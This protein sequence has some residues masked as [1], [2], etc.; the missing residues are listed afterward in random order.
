M[1]AG[2]VVVDDRDPRIDYTTAWYS[3]PGQ[4]TDYNRT[5]SVSG[6][7]NAGFQFTF[8]GTSVAVYGSIPP[9]NTAV[10]TYTIDVSAPVTYTNVPSSA[11]TSRQLCFQS[12]T[13]PDGAHTLVVDIPGSTIGH[14]W[15][16]F[17]FDFLSYVPAAGGTPD[18]S[19]SAASSSSANAAN[20]TGAAGAQPTGA[21]SPSKPALRTILPAVLIPCIVCAALAVLALCTVRRRARRALDAERRATPYVA[22]TP[23]TRTR[24]FSA[25]ASSP[26]SAPS[27]ASLLP[28]AVAVPALLEGGG[29]GSMAGP[30]PGAALRPAVSNPAGVPGGGT[31][32]AG[33]RERVREWARARGSVFAPS[34]ATQEPPPVYMP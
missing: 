25:A 11:Y 7:P 23:E 15:T 3:E 26:T 10:S 14:T 34:V 6:N 4:G 21:S 9:N 31:R 27:N 13:L 20:P 22:P 29:G 5:V 24:P 2:A 18:A 30:G 16:E 8:R 19:S 1:Q 17:S 32:D 33:G 28:P 12:P